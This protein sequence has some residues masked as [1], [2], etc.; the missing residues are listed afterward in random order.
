MPLTIVEGTPTRETFDRCFNEAWDKISAERQR[1]GDSELRE[2]LWSTLSTLDAVSYVID[3]YT[4]GVGSHSVF[5]RDGESWMWYR[6]PTFG[7]DQNGSR[8][9]FYSEEFQ[10]VSYEYRL[11]KGFVGLVVVA[12]TNSPASAAV[13]TI[14]GAH[15]GF[16]TP[17][18]ERA[19]SE[20]FITEIASTMPEGTIVFESRLIPPAS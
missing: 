15:N 13:R 7:C 5:D 2:A 4:V 17:P 14:W 16:Y 18:A 8:A 1:L 10:R 19:P 20:V 11:S 9:W 12:N 3:G 6:Y